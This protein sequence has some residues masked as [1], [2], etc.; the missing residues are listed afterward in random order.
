MAEIVETT[1]HADGTETMR[2]PRPDQTRSIRLTRYRSVSEE[3]TVQV[4]FPLY[5]KAERDGYAGT[6][7]Y[8]DTATFY[9]LD[10]DGTLLSVRHEELQ[11]RGYGDV[12]EEKWSIRK[13]RLSE[14]EFASYAD[15]LS[16][17]LMTAEAEE[18]DEAFAQALAFLGLAVA[19]HQEPT[20]PTR[21]H[22]IIVNGQA[23]EVPRSEHD[24]VPGV[25]QRAVEM[26]GYPVDRGWEVKDADGRRLGC[27]D[28]PDRIR[29]ISLPAGTAS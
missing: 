13:A 18:F 6:V 3:V 22:T 28:D 9:R 26:A 7:P 10:A 24:H 2:T 29:H 25:A 15:R 21:V 11:C 4:T 1:T 23:F 16:G 19:T 27:G 14:R 8:T 17:R 12:H 5:A 20:S